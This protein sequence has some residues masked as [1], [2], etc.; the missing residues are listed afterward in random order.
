MAFGWGHRR[1]VGTDGAPV[2]RR[3]HPAGPPVGVPTEAAAPTARPPAANRPVAPP[4]VDGPGAAPADSTTR[5]PVAA[6]VLDDDAT[7][8]TGIPVAGPT[9]RSRRRNCPDPD[10]HRPS[11]RW[12]QP[13]PPAP[14]PTP[15]AEP[16]PPQRRMPRKLTVTR[17]AALRS[18]EI[19]ENGWRAFHR[20]A[21]ADGADRS[22]LTALTYAT[23][24]NYAVDAAVAVALANTLFFAA[25]TA[26]SR[27]NVALYLAITVAPFAIV[28]PVI[29]PLLDRLQRGRR[30]ALAVSF[31]GRALLAVVMAFGYDSW[32]LYPAALGAMVL[33]KSFGVLKA[34]VTPRVLPAAITLVTTNSRLTTFGLA[35][36]AVFGGIAAGVAAV[37]GSPGALLFTAL[38]GAA[39]VLLC[40]RIPA[41]VEVTEGEVPATLHEAEPQPRRRTPMGRTVLVALW[42]NGAARVLTGFLTLFVAFVVKAQTET[43]PTR[44]LLLIGVVGAAAGLG[45]FAGNAIGA[46]Q[47]FDHSEALVLAAVG[48]AATGA[49]FAAVLPGIGTVALAALVAATCSAL[50]KVA[51]DAVVQREL[52]EQSR[53]SAFGRSETVLQ[54]AWVFGGALGV[55]LPHDTFRLGFGVVAGV[56]V[57]A[58][59]QA[60][61][62]SRGKTLIPLPRRTSP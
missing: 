50:A 43:E 42:G 1:W 16:E 37:W 55:L 40:L 6:D 34:A 11:P 13:E 7:P 52:P 15:D 48:I 20:A 58:G 49:A 10:L 3:W 14:E 41:W 32:V 22:G 29:G 27:T 28:A 60:V 46:R 26:E 44:Q 38:L 53:A 62:V 4:T 47:R 19:T 59:T 9:V 8:P 61:L 24:T 23:M 5:A 2:I 35:S 45:S 57:L 21:T 30:M 51:L 18:R 33:S 17:V 39:G 25:A 54:L 31:G 36:G 56:M 12:G